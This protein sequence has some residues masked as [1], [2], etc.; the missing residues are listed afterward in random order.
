MPNQCDDVE[1]LLYTLVY[2]L[3]GKLPWVEEEE[4]EELLEQRK[5]SWML[6]GS[7]SLGPPFSN[8]AEELKQNSFGDTRSTPNYDKM[9]AMF[10]QDNS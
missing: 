4:E 5:Y 3:L 8:L 1:S 9:I 2:C 10:S 6:D 7:A